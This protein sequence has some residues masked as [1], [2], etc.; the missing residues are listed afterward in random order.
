ME[1]VKHRK[2]LTLQIFATDL[3]ADAIEIARKGHFPKT[4]VA[5]VSPGRIARFFTEEGD[6]YRLNTSIREI[7]VFATHNVIRDPPFTKL[8]I[9]SCRNMLIYMEP[10]MQKK[11]VTLFNYSLNQAGIMILGTAETIGEQNEGFEEI[12]TKLKIYQRSVTL[13]GH[14]I[15][16][17]SSS[18]NSV[19]AAATK[20][21]K[22]S[23][24]AG[25]IQTIADQIILQRFAPASVLVNVNGD[26]QYITGH[27]GKYLEPPAGKANWNIHAM[28]REGLN[29]ALPGAFRK[30]LQNFDVVIL[31]NIK[32][33][34]NGGT[35]FVDV[36]IQ[37][38]ENPQAVRGM[39]MVV[40]TDVPD[41]LFP[42]DAANPKAG[43]RTTG[44][45]HKELEFALQQ[46]RE[47]NRGIREEMQTSQEELKSTNE[48]L[49]S[50]NEEFQS[51]NEELTTSREEMQ[52]M[53]EEM[54][55]INT[56]LK[57]KLSEYLLLNDDMRNML[58]NTDIATLFLDNELNISR[59]TPM[60]ASLFK[61]RNTDI[62]RPFTD[63]VTNLEYP[64]IKD[65]ARQVAKTLIPFENA[66]ATNDNRWFKVRIMPYRTTDDRIN[67]LVMT[68]AD[69]TLS[70]HLEFALRETGAMLRS[71]IHKVSGVVIGMS[72]D[73]K[74]IE[75]N[76]EAEKVFGRK[77]TAVMGKK[78]VDL[79]IPEPARKK[80][81]ADLQKLLTGAKPN[82][83]ENLVKAANGK[84]LNIEWSA[85]KL[86]DEKGKLTGIITI[87]ENITK[88]ATDSRK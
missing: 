81:E 65:Q 32:V 88:K 28:A 15:S 43:K 13:P 30:A 50:S 60:V 51:T 76:P 24:V 52:S 80:V 4:T 42:P 61:I 27:T 36:T 71:F 48:E 64:A 79:F 19:K 3:D 41:S 67:G 85:H 12:D 5:D 17:F 58:D 39:I 16:D 10:Q 74:V 29:H 68:F 59:F 31:R 7:V 84:Q 70:K 82:R 75:F 26:I 87:G 57:I 69:I 49:Q 86:F 34:T 25:N 8:D 47:E 37:R 66:I 83:F 63:Q 35:Q 14:E 23:E 45:R 62:G 11:L 77:R 78:Y 38:I 9:L 40:F 46:S 72:S 22:P 56:Q 2:N 54:Q 73:G 53:N 20:Q 44:A 1:K 21:P 18:F 6:G 33:G 55:T